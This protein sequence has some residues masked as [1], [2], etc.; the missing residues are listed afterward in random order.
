VHG[1][2]GPSAAQRADPGVQP[3]APLLQHPAHGSLH[4]ESYRPRHPAA[5]PV[6][7][8]GRPQRDL[9]IEG[10][11][12][13]AQGSL[14]G[15]V[16][17]ARASGPRGQAIPHVQAVAPLR[18]QTD[19]A[20]EPVLMLDRKGVFAAD[21]PRVAAAGQPFF[22]VAGLVGHR[23]RCPPLGQWVTTLRDDVVLVLGSMCTQGDAIAEEGGGPVRRLHGVTL[24]VF[25]GVRQ[26]LQGR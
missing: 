15:T 22:R 8:D 16:G 4:A 9:G 14:Q 21:L 17:E 10:V 20:G 2:N 24:A 13:P 11:E 18:A 19:A 1:E 6:P 26:R 12:G 5:G 23:D 25:G 3:D 7:G